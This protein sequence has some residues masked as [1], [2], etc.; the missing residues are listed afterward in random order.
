MGAIG[1]SVNNIREAQPYMTPVMPFLILP[2]ILIVPAA[3]DPI[4]LC[5][6]VLSYVPPLTPFMMIGRSAAPPP[7]VDYV[8]T[9]AA[10]R[11]D[12]RDRAVCGR[13]CV[14]AWPAER[15]RAA[16][17]QRDACVGPQRVMSKQG[18]GHVDF[19][20]QWP[21]LVHRGSRDPVFANP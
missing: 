12:R 21:P 20:G 5:A 2:L 11:G 13:A 3:K 7:L 19:D 14:P 17:A 9:A 18:C 6:R 8:A 10:A 1:A 16:Q 15:R 4:A